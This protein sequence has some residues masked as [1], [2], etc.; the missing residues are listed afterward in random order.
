MESPELNLE[1]V[2]P[3]RGHR[4]QGSWSDS[5]MNRQCGLAELLVESVIITGQE[6]QDRFRAKV[7]GPRITH[8]YRLDLTAT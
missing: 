3:W 1:R 2:A 4:D 7:L 8:S 6:G 5:R